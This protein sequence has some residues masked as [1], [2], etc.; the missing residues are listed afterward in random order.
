M[1]SKRIIIALVLSFAVFFGWQALFPPAKTAKTEQA[2]QAASSPSQAPDQVQS[3]APDQAGDADQA[4]AE[5]AETAVAEA[6]A[7]PASADITPTEGKPVTVVTPLY[8][9]VFDSQGGRLESLKLAK[10]ALSLD[11][12]KNGDPADRVELV[13]DH[14]TLGLLID[15]ASTWQNAQ[16]EA[17]AEG[18]LEVEGEFALTFTGRVG[19]YAVQRTFTFSDATY[20]IK[21]KIRVENLGEMRDVD[22]TVAGRTTSLATTA[23]R[24]NRTQATGLGP[25]GLFEEADEDTLREEGVGPYT[26][27]SWGGLN[28]NYFIFAMLPESKDAAMRAGLDDNGYWTSFSENLG[29]VG[30]DQA[31]STD[32][33][34]YIGPMDR[35]ALAQ[36]DAALSEAVY[37]G[38]FDFL[39]KPLLIFLVWIYD[40]VVANYGVA[41]I[42]LTIIIKLIFWPLSQ[43]SY[44]SME[45]MK[46]LQPMIMKLREKYKDDKQKLNQE[47]MQ[48]YKTYKVNPA[49]GCLPMVVQIPVFFGLYKALLE[50]LE[51]RHASFI[52]HVPF[53]NLPW[54]A[55]LSQP[56]PYYVTPIIM[57]LTMFL[58]QRM[59]PST[60]DPT[61]RKIM[62]ALPI[63]FT[64]LFLGFPAG[65]VVYWLCNNVL[66]IA[67][68]YGLARKNKRSKE[69]KA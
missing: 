44:K 53:T 56:D 19:Q 37:F 30:K 62:M 27:L 61:Q 57:G 3:Q 48:L 41:I 29:A 18:T 35:A 65:L 23:S 17:S 22:L 58:Q 47:T 51:L 32:M 67:Q 49:G 4:P 50:A 63:V 2:E 66:S 59:S 45:Q 36:A 39:A 28:N 10:Y 11:G 34:Y 31:E 14:P 54:L 42:I 12:D 46:K 40:N 69:S 7:M 16:W 60:G 15:D 13:G 1:D 33:R 38:W 24:F 5:E 26:S 8:T 43:K 6:A 55:D 64:F 52:A 20:L 21:E 68:Q 25:E 9:A